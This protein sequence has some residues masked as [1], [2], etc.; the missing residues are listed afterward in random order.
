MTWNA[1]YFRLHFQYLYNKW[2]DQPPPAI[3][4][5]I[6]VVYPVL[7]CKGTNKIMMDNVPSTQFIG[8]G[9]KNFRKKYKKIHEKGT[10]LRK[11]PNVLV[12]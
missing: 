7:S 6:K 11:S 12:I 3:R 9:D 2:C 1:T 4:E 8:E 5:E 10:S